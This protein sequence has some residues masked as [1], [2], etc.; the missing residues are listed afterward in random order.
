MRV[1][2]CDNSDGLR[3]ASA[4]KNATPPGDLY[5]FEEVPSVLQASRHTAVMTEQKVGK[6]RER[7]RRMYPKHLLS[8]KVLTSQERVSGFPEKG[9][10]LRGSLGNFRETPGLLLSSTMRELPEKSPKNFREV[11]GT[12]GKVRGLS[13][14]LGEPDSLP[15]I[16]AA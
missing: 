2:N 15:A 13:R 1:G 11:W 16:G 4:G 5:S 6:T 10:D 3:R 8:E 7:L 12:S 14:S 9:A